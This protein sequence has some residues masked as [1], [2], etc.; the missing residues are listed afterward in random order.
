MQ[1]E[2]EEQEQQGVGLGFSIAKRLAEVHGGNMTVRSKH[3]EGTRV[4]VQLPIR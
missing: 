1:F 2:R 4:H 3:G